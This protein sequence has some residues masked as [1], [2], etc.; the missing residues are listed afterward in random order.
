MSTYDV[1]V[2]GTGG[3][4]CATMW[5]LA[6]RGVRVLGLDRFPVAH[7]RGS[8]HGES[9]IIRQ[10]YFE[11]PDYVPLLR[12]TYEL[13]HDIEQAAQQ[14]L[15]H[16]VGLIEIGPASGVVVP[17]VLE[18][19]RRYQ[20]RVEK[21]SAADCAQRYPAFQIPPGCEVVFEPDAGYLLVEESLQA[22]A[23]MASR[24]GALFQH[25]ETV[26]AWRV[27]NDSVEVTTTRSTYS[28]ARLIVTAGAWGPTLLHDL[29]V[30]LRVLRKHLYWYAT[31]PNSPGSAALPAF[32]YELPQ[33]V[34]Y[35]IAGRMPA[36]IKVGEHSGGWEVADPLNASRAE[37]PLDRQRV[38]AFV[39]QY[40]Q[41]VTTQVVRHSACLYTMSPDEH[42]IVDRLPHAPQVVFAA[43][44]SGH[45]FKFTP[46]LGEIL[47]DLAIQGSSTLPIEF[48]RLNR[49]QAS[50]HG[51]GR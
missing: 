38:D 4:G 8:S 33:G 32:L 9:R 23:A 27:L 25:D 49:F 48:L 37:D 51:G 1:I 50:G 41:G 2:M 42:F 46:V 35:G 7:D 18:S 20:V 19:A 34:F 30:P 29:G 39:S 3:V 15:Y 47:A 21:L 5:Q 31:S 22:Q 28:A 17:G 26:L 44:L 10:A 36:E 6:Q 16:P 13:W 40:L 45:G 12:R 24:A 14:T 11:H 43:G